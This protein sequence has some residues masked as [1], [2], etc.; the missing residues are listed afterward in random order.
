VSNI[1]IPRNDMSEYQDFN[2]V[3]TVEEI[4][5][6]QSNDEMMI[7]KVIGESLVASYPGREWCVDVDIDGLMVVISCQSLSLD[8]G[9]HIAMAGRN[10]IELVERARRGAGEILE[11]YGISRNRKFNSDEINGLIIHPHTGEA[12]VSGGST[13]GEEPIK[14]G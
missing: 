7:A 6:K 2:R 12:F 9:Y 3:M 14:R 5:L 1:V 13:E 4:A 11:R 8:K 10:V